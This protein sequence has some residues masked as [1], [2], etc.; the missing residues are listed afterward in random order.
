MPFFITNSMKFQ[1]SRTAQLLDAML[2]I[3][4]PQTWIFG[5]HHNSETLNDKGCL[6]RCLNE[7]ETFELK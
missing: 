6:F 3:H 7:L 5:H 1:P 4:R 2:E